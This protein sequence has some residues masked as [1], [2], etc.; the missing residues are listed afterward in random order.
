M[1]ET[2][3]PS[4]SSAGAAGAGSPTDA[5]PPAKSSEAGTEGAKPA[6]SLKDHLFTGDSSVKAKMAAEDTPPSDQ[7][8]ETPSDD[9]PSSQPAK[10]AG[11]EGAKD[12]NAEQ[13]A[14][15]PLTPEEE[16]KLPFHK[17]PRWRQ[18]KNEN[19]EMR[20]KL[21]AAEPDAQAFQQFVGKVTDAKLSGGDLDQLLN[22]GKTLKHDPN[23]AYDYLVKYVSDLGLQLG[24][25]L[26]PDLKKRVDEGYLTE[27]DAQR[28]AKAEADKNLTT[29]Q[30][31]EDERNEQAKNAATQKN[32]LMT[33]LSNWEFDW[34]SKDADY[35]VL[36]PEVQDRFVV[37]A[38]EQKPKT[39]KEIR[40]IADQALKDV[41][42]RR[43]MPP[44][45]AV[46]PPIQSGA[47]VQTQTVPKTMRDSMIQA[48]R[49][50]RK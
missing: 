28:L 20:E 4:A 42:S 22:V 11:E 26:P 10:A 27:E 8:R 44:P 41:R 5:N 29:A 45:N 14:E 23:A 36:Q 9:D 1:P 39:T 12:P 15:K 32:A 49:A 16:A 43:K 50:G 25:T 21:A 38:R 24:R 48:G 17:H 18:M 33:E 7:S 34:K 40:A 19:A 30:R 6:R 13:E 37:L 31:E 2:L 47:S 46:R 3:T 35:E